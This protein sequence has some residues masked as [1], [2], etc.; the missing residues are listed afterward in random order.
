[1]LGDFREAGLYGFC[2]GSLLAVNG[3]GDLGGQYDLDDL[4]V[5]D[6]NTLLSADIQQEMEQAGG[7]R[8]ELSA[9]HDTFWRMI[10][11]KRPE[12]IIIL[13]CAAGRSENKLVRQLWLS[14]KAA[15]STQQVVLRNEGNLHQREHH[16]VMIVRGFHPSTYLRAGSATVR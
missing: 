5:F 15:G 7:L 16:E 14:L 2:V 12:V 6:I 8:D 4:S 10:L 13:T 3:L 11:A 1:M 9:A